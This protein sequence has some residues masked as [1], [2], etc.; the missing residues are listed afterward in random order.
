ML[1]LA[2]FWAAE[3]YRTPFLGMLIE[4]NNIVSQLSSP[5]WPARSNGVIFADRLL[6]LNDQPIPNASAYMDFLQQNGTKPVL[7]SFTRRAGGAFQL[8]II[9]SLIRRWGICLLCSSCLISLAL[10]FWASGFGR[11]PCAG[12]S[13]P[14][15]LCWFSQPR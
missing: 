15:M 13:V 5:G 2:P 7:A 9:R 6:A 1:V 8:T 4:P 3:W 11:T 14:V 10:H 12:N